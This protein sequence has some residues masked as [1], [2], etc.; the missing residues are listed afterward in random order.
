MYGKIR[1]FINVST[2]EVYGETSLVSAP[3]KHQELLW[4]LEILAPGLPYQKV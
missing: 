3:A 4:L 1:R 2:D